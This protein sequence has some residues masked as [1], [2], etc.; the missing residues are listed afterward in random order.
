MNKGAY[1]FYTLFT[2]LVVACSVVDCGTSREP[3]VSPVEF[4]VVR[5]M[6]SCA[7]CQNVVV[8]SVYGNARTV[9][10]E[11]VATLMIPSEGVRRSRIDRARMAENVNLEWWVLRLEWAP[12]AQHALDELRG[13][14][15]SPT[16]EILVSTPRGPLGIVFAATLQGSIAIGQFASRGAATNVAYAV[17]DEETVTCDTCVGG[18]CAELHCF[19]CS[20]HPEAFHCQVG[21]PLDIDPG[22]GGGGGGGGGGN[23]PVCCPEFLRAAAYCKA[24]NIFSYVPFACKSSAPRL[25]PF[26]GLLQ[27]A[28][29]IEIFDP[30]VPDPEIPPRCLDEEL[31]LCAI[32]GQQAADCQRI[33]GPN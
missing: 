15:A 10:V 32:F 24:C 16:T 23:P 6:E 9:A 25:S 17:Q 4:R 12:D 27:A 2:L 21:W 26:S 22:A 33:H 1:F 5:D 11:P 8:P 31:M 14:V 20:V 13:S 18:Q 28:E 30:P 19:E 3:A 7:S 29:S